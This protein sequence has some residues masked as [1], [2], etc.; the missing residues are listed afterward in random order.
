MRRTIILARYLI[1]EELMTKKNEVVLE[2][3]RTIISKKEYG[4]CVQQIE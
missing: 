3:E 2:D 4:R 1:N